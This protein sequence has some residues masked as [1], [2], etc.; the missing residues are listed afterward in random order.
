MSFPNDSRSAK[1]D[2]AIDLVKVHPELSALYGLT[3]HPKFDTN[4]HVYVCYV[5]KNDVEDGSVVSRFEASR[6]DPPVIDPASEKVLLR[7]YSGGHNGGCLDFG[8]DGYLYISTGDGGD[9]AP[10][11]ER[12]R[13]AR[14]A[15]TSSPASFVSTLTTPIPARLTLFPPTIRSSRLPASGPR[16]GPSASATPGG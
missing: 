1:A 10:P 15:P 2:L 16:S 11:D 4:R 7:F 14:T 12:R 13:P 3:F 9:A 8:T 6:S 5:L